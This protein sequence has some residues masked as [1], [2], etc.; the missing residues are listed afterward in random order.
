M[1]LFIYLFIFCK[2]LFENSTQ[3]DYK[4]NTQC[5]Q[6][7]NLLQ[8]GWLPLQGSSG[9]VL[10]RRQG[11]PALCFLPSCSIMA[12]CHS[13]RGS[14]SPSRSFP[15]FRLPL[16]G[17]L[18]LKF[19]MV[20]PAHCALRLPWTHLTIMLLPAKEMV[21]WFLAT[22]NYVMFLQSPVGKLIWVSRWKW[23]ATSPPITASPIQLICLVCVL[24]D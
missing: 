18:A 23:V 16:S 21:M 22:T 13:F 19:H 15:N 9:R 11:S 2:L 17:G 24:T 12:V 3:L 1:Q 7:V 14:W 8:A 5:T 4:G 6:N 10:H 20:L